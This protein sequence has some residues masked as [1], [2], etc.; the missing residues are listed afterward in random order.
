M[1][2]A[3]QLGEWPQYAQALTVVGDAERFGG[4][5]A[6]ARAYYEEAAHTGACSGRNAAFTM[7]E[8]SFQD[9][10]IAQAHR[11]AAEA[12]ACARPPSTVELTTLVRLLR[13]GHAVLDRAAVTAKI[14]KVR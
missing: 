9:H 8:M 3:L 7:A 5:F 10:R 4:R 12:P 6:L 1:T 11:L 2:M 14:A 13:T